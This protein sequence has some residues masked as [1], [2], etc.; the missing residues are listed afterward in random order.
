[1]DRRT[2][3][4]RQGG[5]DSGRYNE[6]SITLRPRAKSGMSGSGIKSRA[7]TNWR[8]AALHLDGNDIPLCDG[9]GRH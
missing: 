8:L 6:N 4:N 9:D 1:M 7:K 2:T 3:A 5:I